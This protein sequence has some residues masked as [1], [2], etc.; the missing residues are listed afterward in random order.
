LRLQPPQLQ[1]GRRWLLVVTAED[2]GAIEAY[3]APRVEVRATTN[4]VQTGADWIKLT[5]A[6]SYVNG[7]LRLEDTQTNLP[8]RFYITVENP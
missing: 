1:A 2:G 8:R 4:L 7:T 5:N 6:L 3:R